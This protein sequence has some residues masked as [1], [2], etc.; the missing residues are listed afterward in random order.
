M[1]R[2]SSLALVVLRLPFEDSEL[3]DDDGDRVGLLLLRVLVVPYEGSEG[4]S[5]WDV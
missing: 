2:S 4:G 1:L 5:C 3:Y